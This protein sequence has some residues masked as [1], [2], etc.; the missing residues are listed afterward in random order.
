MALLGNWRFV[1]PR[2]AKQIDVDIVL[3]IKKVAIDLETNLIAQTPKDT[4][5]AAASWVV[6]VNKSPAPRDL[7]E[8]RGRGSLNA[9]VQ[10]AVNAARVEINR[11]LGPGGYIEIANH[12]SYIRQ[13]NRGSSRQA[14]RGF[15]QAAI[16]QETLGVD[17]LSSAI[18]RN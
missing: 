10:G 15:V 9:E 16:R 11:P 13:L 2:F 17:R 7:P 18:I 1:L 4:G 12:V 6:G 3:G 5:R 8:G 14:P